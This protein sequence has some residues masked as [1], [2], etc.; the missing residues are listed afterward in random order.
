MRT[1]E[2]GTS[3]LDQPRK[4]CVHY[5][6][7][8]GANGGGLGLAPF[9]GSKSSTKD[10]R[11]LHPGAKLPRRL[12]ENHLTLDQAFLVR[13]QAG[14]P[15]SFTFPIFYRV[16]LRFLHR[17]TTGKRTGLAAQLHRILHHTA[18]RLRR[19]PLVILIGDLPIVLAGNDGAVSHRAIF[20]GDAWHSGEKHS[21]A[22]RCHIAPAVV[23]YR[24]KPLFVKD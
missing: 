14:Q 22:T 19:C 18:G 24:R 6:L 9:S 11:Q 7:A 2:L 8:R 10:R 1:R 21:A 5:E 4:V 13:V 12:M 15:F 16:F 20:L 23:W 3:A 17:P